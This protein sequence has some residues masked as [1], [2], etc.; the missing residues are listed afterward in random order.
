MGACRALAA[1]GDAAPILRL[2]RH[3]SHGINTHGYG[4]RFRRS[5][6]RRQQQVVEP[7]N[8]QEWDDREAEGV[9]GPCGDA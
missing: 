7:A 2:R 5:V 6:L 8:V 4:S 3:E 9:L 1:H